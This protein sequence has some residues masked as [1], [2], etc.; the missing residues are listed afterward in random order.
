[1]N[2]VLD[3]NMKINEERE[4]QRFRAYSVAGNTRFKKTEKEITYDLQ[5]MKHTFEHARY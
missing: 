4:R 3:L 2:F 5:N 1:M